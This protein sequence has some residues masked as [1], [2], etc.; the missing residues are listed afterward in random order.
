LPATAAER[1]L[2]ARLAGL[3]VTVALRRHARPA[4][5]SA[6]PR[7]LREVVLV[8]GSGGVLRHG[9]GEVRRAVLH[10]AASD[11]AGA[12]PVPEHARTTVDE[13]YL[14]F[15]AGLLATEYP[16]AARA[17]AGLIPLGDG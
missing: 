5:P 6:A 14:L 17:L 1:A 12:W 2:D 3:A 10:A 15:A 4:T 8:V 9:D 16:Q 11:H 7:P 13:Q